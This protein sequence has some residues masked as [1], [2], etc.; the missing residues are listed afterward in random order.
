REE[1][2]ALAHPPA[3][4]LDGIAVRAL[5]WVKP[6]GELGSLRRAETIVGVYR[7][8]T[9]AE[10]DTWFWSLMDGVET[11]AGSGSQQ[12]CVD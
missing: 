10:A 9:Y 11:S 1:L 12:K 5:E 6:T 3:K 8:W 2:T 4:A 7:V